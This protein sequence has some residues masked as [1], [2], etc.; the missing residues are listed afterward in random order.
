MEQPAL[1]TILRTETIY[2]FR[3]EL[4][5]SSSQAGQEYIID[6]T[7][8]IRERLRRPLHSVAQ[9]MQTLAQTDVKRQTIRLGAVSDSPLSI[10]RR[11][12]DTSRTSQLQDRT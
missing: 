5:E 6:L 10:R 7:P 4:P 11:H 12:L 9:N 2:R 1:L 8:E 3:L